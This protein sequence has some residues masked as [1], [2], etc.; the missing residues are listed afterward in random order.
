MPEGMRL[1]PR[2]LLLLLLLPLLLAAEARAA[3]QR[4]GKGFSD[5]V[6]ASAGMFVASGDG[7]VR[8][9]DGETLPVAVETGAMMTGLAVSEDGRQVAAVGVGVVARSSDGGKTFRVEPTPDGVTVYAAAFSGGDLLLFDVTGRG[10]RA[11]EAQGFKPLLLPRSGHFWT[12]S[13]SGQ[14]GYVVGERGAFLA[15]RDGGK[16]WTELKSPEP[17][18][19]GVLAMGGSVWVSGKGG[20]F[21]STDAGRTFRKVYSTPEGHQTSGCARMGGRGTAVVVG[22]TPFE[23][24]LAYA[25]DGVNFQEVPVRD[26]ANLLSASISPE[27]ELWAVGAWELLVRATPRKGRLLSHSEQTHKWLELMEKKRAAAQ[28]RP[29]PPLPA[30]E[31]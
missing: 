26:A 15:T 1:P 8:R 29:P 30:H 14:R 20:V 18:P 9:L 2:A 25:A 10:F 16:T 27:G 11:K 5:V 22:C 3:G 17:E 7:T 28:P 21:R 19:Q 4:L 24:T 12:A 31:D 13:F 6:H 23:H